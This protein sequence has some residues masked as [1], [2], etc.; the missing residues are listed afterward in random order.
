MTNQAELKP[1]GLDPITAE[2]IMHGLSAIP[3]LV[4]KNIARTAYSFLISEYK[5]Y[6]VGIVDCDGKLITQSRGGLPIFVANALSAAVSDGLSIYGHAQLKHGDV[7]I[8]NHAGS[9]GQH[10]N[11]VVMYTPIRT[12]DADTDLIGF[13]AVV[14]HWMDVGGITIGSCQSPF[15]T[16]IFQEGIQFRTVKLLSCGERVE[17]M[18]RMVAEN[19]R[20][21]KLVLGDLEAQI[22]GCVA[23][24]D[25]VAELVQI[26][27]AAAIRAAVEH[28]WFR[29]EAATRA[30]IAAIPD[31]EYRA[32]SFLDDDGIDRGKPVEIVAKVVIRGDEAIIDLSEVAAQ[33]K[34][35][36]NSGYQG[37]AVAASRMAAKYVFSPDGP[38][39]YGA[40]KP[41]Q[42][43]CPPGRFL[44]AGP[45]AP[46]GGSGFTIPTVVDTIL[47]ALASCL[48]ER[49]PAAHHGTYSVHVIDGHTEEGELFQHIESAAGGW[50][51]G[52]DRDG[53]GP[54]RSMAHGDTLEVPV[55]LQESSHPYLIE[56][57]RLR[58]DSGGAGRHRGGLGLEK[59]YRMKVPGRLTTS[60]ERTACAP[61]GLDDGH[62][63][64]PG[65]VDVIR[66]DGSCLTLLKGE[67]RLAAGDRILL[68][69]AGG[70]GFGD[71]KSRDEQ[72]IARD[73]SE[74]YVSAE[75]ASELYGFILQ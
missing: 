57:V 35:P 25:L 19:T 36:L 53:G 44:S 27:G 8:S 7:V 67:V 23:G 28:F 50:G 16:D 72:S 41:I 22:A 15:T 46:I 11:N 3:N 1:S 31:G 61:W 2:V 56:Y 34:G 10:L 29:A 9:M 65:R 75:S 74:G 4:D 68:F 60:I 14:M 71:P 38:A 49:I 43:V 63:G 12:G 45:T 54:F 24:R 39:N 59:A 58:R 17:D 21:P 30:V 18:F 69:T 42:V 33:L 64:V 52:C 37:G 5:D 70:G 26:W 73:V 47:R 32:C 20:F 13:F 48:P 62:S 55:E 40:F 6:A 66:N 51:A